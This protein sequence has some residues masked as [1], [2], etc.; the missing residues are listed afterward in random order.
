MPGWVRSRRWYWRRRADAVLRAFWDAPLPSQRGEW[1][2]SGYLV[3]DA[4]MSSLDPDQGELLSL[5]WVAIDSGAITLASA[6]HLVIRAQASVG[7][8]ATV[9]RLR[10]CEVALG[11]SPVEALDALLHAARGRLLVFHNATLDMA[12][13]D[14]LCMACHGAPLLQPWLCTLTLEQRRLQRRE[15]V[16]RHGDLT[17]AGCRARYQLPQFHAH[18]ALWD[19]LATAELLLAHFSRP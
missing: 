4:E 17:L 10:D 12:Y 7:Q 8:S 6:R 3:V 13:L 11:V 16:L 5:G 19:A 15:Q 18:N 14:R 2:D 9:H 1:R